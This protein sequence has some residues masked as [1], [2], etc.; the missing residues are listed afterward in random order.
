MSNDGMED[1]TAFVSRIE[2]LATRSV[3]PTGAGS[4][5][6]RSWGEGPPLVLLHGASGSW[7][8]WIRNVL[9]LA[10]RF[11]VLAPDM[12]GFGDSDSP[13]EPHTADGLADL[14]AA[15]LDVVLPPPMRLDLA[16]FSFGAIMAGLVAARLARRVSKV[17][18]VGTGGLGLGLGSPRGLARIDASMS[19]EEIR[20]A[21]RANLLAL[22]L[23]K[24]ES[25]D[26]LAVSLQIEN[27]RRARFKSGTI[28]QSDV[29]RR[30]LPLIR[31]RIAGIW[32]GSDAFADG[33]LDACRRVLTSAQADFDFRV[34]EGAGHWVPYEAADQINAA[35]FEL[36]GR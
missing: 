12:P 28:P 15:S 26:D 10:E 19:R 4:M 14:L 8:H 9:P 23:A 11:H 21:H 32:G 16:G 2:A 30:A 34:I 33:R 27:L 18:L 31:A 13:P 5:V 17:V 24:P 25:A 22:M 1:A 20:G 36:L 7:T 35:L 29:L 6:W 3:A